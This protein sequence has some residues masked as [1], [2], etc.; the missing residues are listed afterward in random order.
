MAHRKSKKRTRAMKQHSRK[1][2]VMVDN[3]NK[4]HADAASKEHDGVVVDDGDDTMRGETVQSET[5]RVRDLH[6]TPKWTHEVYEA[7]GYTVGTIVFAI[8]AAVIWGVGFAA[9][10]GVVVI[11]GTYFVTMLPG[12]VLSSL[13][14]DAQVLLATPDRFLFSWVLPVLF[15]TIVFG[16]ACAI[17]VGKYFSWIHRYT[18][19]LRRGLYAG[20]GETWNE[21][22]KCRKLE[23]EHRKQQKSVDKA[24]RQK[25]RKAV[26]ESEERLIEASK[27]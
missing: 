21:N 26:A 22:R 14:V 19:R 5:S 11:A 20:H 15:I 7:N 25:D 1:H 6:D 3:A 13:G 12:V 9:M 23:R 17:G 18:G 2:E 27:K 10:A 8:A 24:R 4:V 16:G